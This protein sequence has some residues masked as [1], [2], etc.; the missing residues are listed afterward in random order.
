[1]L[2][3][4]VSSVCTEPDFLPGGWRRLAALRVPP[5]FP[6]QA[7]GCGIGTLLS[8]A[9]Q[10]PRTG[11]RVRRGVLR[12]RGTLV[13]GENYM[14]PS[15]RTVKNSVFLT[16]GA[17]REPRLSPP[18]RCRGSCLKSWH[19][20]PLLLSLGAQPWGAAW[21]PLCAPAL[22]S[23]E[24][25]RPVLAP[26]PLFSGCALG[27]PC[28]R[29]P[30]SEQQLRQGT[31]LISGGVGAALSAPLTA[32]HGAA[33][34]HLPLP[35]LPPLLGSPPEASSCLLDSQGS[36][37]SERLW[38]GARQQ[39]ACLGTAPRFPTETHSPLAVPSPGWVSPASCTE[40]QTARCLSLLQPQ[41]AGGPIIQVRAARAPSGPGTLQRGT[42]A[43]RRLP[44]PQAS[45]GCWP[46]FPVTLR[47]PC[48]FTLGNALVSGRF[49][50]FGT[51]PCQFH[52]PL[53]AFQD[54]PCDYHTTC[55][56]E[57]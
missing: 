16:L 55:N 57:P 34:T 12:V 28:R 2:V 36:L 7:P 32:G 42:G 20:R 35:P 11:L 3:C 49:P 30:S 19:A 56:R 33:E 24:L 44:A 10:A 39:P 38:A 25:A 46:P 22:Q 54:I 53:I 18:S 51:A 37:C 31:R 26:C 6:P 27:G 29:A 15:L 5:T 9:G 1:M 45:G 14:L 21:P 41:P 17:P 40:V 50:G 8:G 52:E 23:P 43:G 4:S 48:R 13:P 47:R